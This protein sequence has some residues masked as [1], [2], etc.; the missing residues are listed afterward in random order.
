MNIEKIKDTV[1]ENRGDFS[2]EETL[3]DFIGS[4]NKDND[5]EDLE[6]YIHEYADG[7]VPVYYNE[8]VKEW[9]ENP[10]CH[11]MTVNALGEYGEGGIYNMMMSDLYFMYFE[12]L[13][14]DYQALLDLYEEDEDTEN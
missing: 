7:L 11:E 9:S 5:L 14:A 10:D 1:K 4:Y 2:D 3:L 6:D 8:I 13:G 12:R